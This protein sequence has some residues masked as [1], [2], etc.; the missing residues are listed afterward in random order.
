V[1]VIKKKSGK[2]RF[3]TDLR[4]VNAS[5]VTMGAL[6]PGLPTPACIPKERPLIVLDLQNCFYTIPI[7]PKDRER[8]A[9]SVPSLNQQEPLQSYQ[10]TMDSAATGYD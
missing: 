7:H 10:W 8:F 6:Q 5:M 9:F 2:W 1:F 4:N 3:L